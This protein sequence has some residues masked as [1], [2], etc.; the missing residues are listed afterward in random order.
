MNA[1]NQNT[2][3]VKQSLSLLIDE[4]GF[5]QKQIVKKLKQLGYSISTSSISNLKNDNES[6]GK[7]LYYQAAKGLQELIK[8]EF[9]QHYDAAQDL[10]T[11]IPNCQ[12]KPV[13]IEESIDVL[14][15]NNS[16]SYTIHNGR[17]NIS[18]K[19][20]LYEQAQYEIIE[21]GL[22]LRSFSAYFVSRREDA[23]LIPIQNQLNKGVHFKCYLLRPDGNCARRYVAD[24]TIALP[25]EHDLLEKIPEIT[26]NLTTQ[27]NALNRIST[28]GK[29][30]LYQYDH[31]P[32]YHATVIDGDTER[33]KILISPYLFGVSRAN[34][35]VIEITKKHHPVIYRQYWKSVKALIHSPQIFPLVK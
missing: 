13:I 12:R 10:L 16:S 22:R 21:I 17:L 3:I 19:V 27:I 31:F 2:R 24:R 9:C 35:P 1:Q 33:G 15:T 29:M 8:R 6:I 18:D 4:K 30:S 23:F 7:K 25:R 34:A 5:S 20:K 11:P 26:A 14:P 32:N 28:K